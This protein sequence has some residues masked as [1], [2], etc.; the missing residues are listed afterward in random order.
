MS[1]G[2]TRKRLLESAFKR[3][4]EY[5]GLSVYTKLDK[6]LP[7]LIAADH[8]ELRHNNT[9]GPL[10]E[11]YKDEI[12]VCLKCGKEEVWKA[13]AQKWWF[14]EAK[15]NINA[16]AVH[17]KECRDKEKSRKDQARKV[18]LEGLAK[19]NKAL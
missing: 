6:L 13:T 12:I 16:T 3:A 18:H 4:H 7:G 8:E 2:G 15:A 17:C 14:E 10:P 1:K 11:F 9:Y 19:R 5:E